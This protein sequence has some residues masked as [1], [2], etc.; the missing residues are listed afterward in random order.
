MTNRTEPPKN[1]HC[2][3][4]LDNCIIIF[5]G[6]CSRRNKP[7]S[8]RV[9]WSYNL[10]TEEWK[11]YVIQET[12]DAPEPFVRAVADT[13]DGTIYTFGG[14][15]KKYLNDLWTLKKTKREC[16][17]WSYI[18][19]QCKEQS[20]SPRTGH[21]GWEYNGK[22]WI[23]GGLGPSPEGY[24]NCNGDT[25]AISPRFWNNQLLCYDPNTQKWS[26]P[27]CFGDVP[28]PR[29][30]HCS[31]IIKNKAWLFG[32]VGRP[33]CNDIFELTMHSLT[34]TQI[35]TVIPHPRACLYSTLTAV[36]EGQLV[37]HGGLSTQGQTWILDLKS[38]SW[39]LYRSREV[40][41]RSCH[42]GSSG[43]N[44]SVIMF[45]GYGSQDVR[46]VFHVAL[47]LLKFQKFQKK[48]KKKKKNVALEAK[49]LQ[50][51]AMKIIYKHQDK[52][53]WEVL[54]AKLISRLDLHSYTVVCDSSQSD[55]S[56]M[57]FCLFICLF[58]WLYL[59]LQTYLYCQ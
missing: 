30:G 31:A 38:H 34:W 21:T 11:E 32:G 8:T 10:Y 33:C 13:I 54:P 27:Q 1:N 6:Y 41:S 51:L 48:K 40:H 19:P 57:D 17:I 4:Y 12:V 18:K 23:F 2:A 9:I 50:Q 24:L 16:F 28:S 49:L 58:G 53:P 45:G 42:T 43:L 55:E 59:S 36:T 52:L 26:N 35:Q 39:R 5:G 15:N 22:L 14:V 3:V 7:I 47:E 20:P 46:D 44:S 29:S 56:C 37:L 25:A